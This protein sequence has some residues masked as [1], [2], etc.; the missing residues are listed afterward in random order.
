MDLLNEKFHDVV[1]IEDVSRM[2]PSLHKTTKRNVNSNKV[3]NPDESDRVNSSSNK[4][5]STS[6]AFKLGK[7]RN[8]ESMA[9]QFNLAYMLQTVH[10]LTFDS[11]YFLKINSEADDL[12]LCFLSGERSTVASNK[13]FNK[14]NQQAFVEKS[15][16]NQQY[17]LKFVIPE[18]DLLELFKH[19]NLDLGKYVEAD[20]WY[21]EESIRRRMQQEQH[22]RIVVAKNGVWREWDNRYFFVSNKKCRV[23]FL[24]KQVS[25]IN[26]Y[27]LLFNSDLYNNSQYT[28]CF[29]HETSTETLYTTVKDNF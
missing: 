1:S 19:H 28:S 24:S 7:S 3:K 6:S 8:S 2:P 10:R 13:F 5:S 15:P 21:N 22:S 9:I 29:Y 11:F 4:T 16:A 27:L 23:I 14:L 17:S 18:N 25:Y 12:E 20:E 26:E